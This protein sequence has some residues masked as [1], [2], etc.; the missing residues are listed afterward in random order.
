M[1]ISTVNRRAKRWPGWVVLTFVVVALVAVGATRDG[2][3]Q[4]QEERITALEKRL[5]CPV[6]SGESVF[7]SRNTG[8][9]QIREF[10]SQEVERGVLDDQQI[11][12]RIV[13][14][15]SGEELL[16][17][18]ASGVEALAWALP[19]TAFVIGVVGLAIAF[20]RWQASARR[21]GTATDDDYA[22]VAAALDRDEP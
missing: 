2:G 21:L 14:N 17:P 11:I 5:A 4:T 10:I 22:L 13:V 12:D 19:A 9:V 15:Y 16:V 1:T 7:V 20:R 8:S 18:T 3:P 6:C